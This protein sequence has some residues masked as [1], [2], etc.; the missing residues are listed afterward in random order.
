[1]NFG[2]GI[3]FGVLNS[4]NVTKDS[5]LNHDFTNFYPTINFNYRFSRTK[6]LRIN[7]SGRTTQPTVQ[8]LEPV[9]DNS[10]PLNIKIGNPDLKQEFTNSL[11]FLY[12]SF[13]PSTFKNMF[14]SINASVIKSD[15]VN[16]TTILSD[17]AQIIQPVNLN[18]AYNVSGFFNYG[19]PV[20]K[21]KGNLNFTTNLTYT[22]GVSLVD[23][24]VN[25]T[26]NYSF[27][28]SF[29]FTTNLKKNFDLN[30]S[31]TPTYNIAN[32]S[33]QPAEN[34]NYF[35]NILNLEPTYY[36]K[37]GW[38]L[39]SAF[40]FTSYS[41]RAAGYN[42][43]VPLWNASIAKQFL[44][45]KA[46]ELKLFVFDLLNQNVSI[47]RTI[48]ENYV[49]DVQTKVLTRYFLV[50]FI[51]NLRKFGQQMPRM[52]HRGDGGGMFPMPPADGNTPAPSSPPPSGPPPSGPPPG[53]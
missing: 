3:Q 52:F 46:G 18:G 49:Q 19:F 53:E 11:R 35:S 30:F 13:N 2:T 45:N 47:N 5:T 43:S 44:K 7:Y 51:Y 25:Y 42:T 21:P 22:R 6:N 8:Q 39:S 14:A 10:D 38:I 29:K 27:G 4:Y 48:T 9:T 28:E 20:K 37:N 34:A 50:S 31:A 15:I 36:T 41:G 33:V 32:Y 12:T 24:E 40:N 17:G 1:M 23:D 26:N 16:S